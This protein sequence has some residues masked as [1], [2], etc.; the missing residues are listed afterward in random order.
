MGTSVNEYSSLDAGNR[1]ANSALG[2]SRSVNKQAYASL[3]AGR[4]STGVPLG[5]RGKRNI[6]VDISGAHNTNLI[7]SMKQPFKSAANIF[8]SSVVDPNQSAT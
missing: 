7:S 6:N 1:F 3:Q 4:H 8:S 5:N 2:R